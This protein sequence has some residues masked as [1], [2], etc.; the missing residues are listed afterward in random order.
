MEN[1]DKNT[2]N[3]E[4]VDVNDPNFYNILQDEIE[5]DIARMKKSLEI[6]RNIRS[7]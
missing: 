5:S 2:N 7:K 6:V 3:L 4:N 1:T